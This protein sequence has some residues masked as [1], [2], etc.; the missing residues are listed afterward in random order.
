MYK[1][2]Y[3]HTISEGDVKRPY[4]ALQ[5]YIHT[6]Q[7]FDFARLYQ[8]MGRLLPCDVGKRVFEVG[9]IYQVENDEQLQAR[10]AKS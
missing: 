4:S 3:V 5:E 8:T 6:K 2:K 10:L 1:G 9:D 7:G